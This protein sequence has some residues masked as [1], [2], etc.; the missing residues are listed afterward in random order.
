[1]SS[2]HVFPILTAAAV[3]FLIGALWYSPLLFAKAWMQAQGHTPEKLAAMQKTAGRA[4]GVSFLCFLLMA[5]VLHL[6]LS[7]VGAADAGSGAHWGALAWLGFAFTIGLTA[8][9]YSDKPLAAFLID[10]GYQLVY[11]VVMGAI[12]AGWQ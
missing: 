8:N 11:L 2:H 12:L 7:S 9:V 6:F 3:A 1:M 5:F 10:T 4:Y